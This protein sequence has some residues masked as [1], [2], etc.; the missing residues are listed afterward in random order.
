MFIKLSHGSS[1]S[2]VIAYRANSRFESAENQIIL[3]EKILNKT[4]QNQR[5]FLFINISAL[6][7]P[8]YFYLE[9]AKTDTLDTHAAALEYI[10]IQLG[11]LWNAVKAALG[12]SSF[13]RLAIGGGTPTQLP[14]HHLEAVLNVAED[15]M[16]ADLQSI[17]ISVEMLPETATKEKLELLRS[18]GGTRASI[19]VQSLFESEAA[20]VPYKFSPLSPLFPLP[21]L[22]FSTRR[23]GRTRMRSAFL[24]R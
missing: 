11:K 18:R 24:Y 2:G 6:H 20:A 15:T 22:L 5:L 9:G 4:P 21:N 7:Q 14:I 1:A 19:G 23:N 3:A 10:D 13:A 16:G 17:P 8:N 12:K